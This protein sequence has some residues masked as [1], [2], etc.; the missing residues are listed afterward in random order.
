MRTVLMLLAAA[1]PSLAAAQHA[2]VTPWM[3]GERLVKLLG[4]VDPATVHLPPP[5]PFAR[6]R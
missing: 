4:N 3:T 6:V 2:N 5:V 1:I